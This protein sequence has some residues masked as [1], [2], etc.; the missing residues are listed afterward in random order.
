[1]LF[2]ACVVRAQDVTLPAPDGTTVTIHRDSYGVPHVTGTTEAGVFF[3]QGFACAED[4]LFQMETY[5]RAAEGKLCEWYGS[6]YL[7]LDQEIRR[8]FYTPAERES[9]FTALPAEIQAMF[10]AYA[11]GVNA[12]LDSMAADPA[13]Y[14]PYEFQEYSMETPWTSLKSVAV[15][16][17]IIGAFGQFGGYELTRLREL[18]QNG[19]AWFDQYRPINDPSA[20]V[21]LHDGPPAPAR[22]W[23]YSGM[24]V[25]PEVSRELETRQAEVERL[26][27]EIGIPTSLGSFAT[28]IAE[29]KSAT[30]NVLALGCPQMG[31]PQLGQANTV[32]EVEL[33]CP[34]FHV[35]GMTLAGTPGVIIGRNE[36]LTWTLTSGI[37]DNT[38]LYI[39][40]T[41]SA[42]YSRYWH[43][44]TWHD[45]EVITDTIYVRNSSPNI[46]T[47]YRTIHGPVSGDDLTN[48]QTFSLK[49]TFRGRELDMA[50]AALAMSRAQTLAEFETAIA[51][52]PMSFNVFCATDEGELGFWHIGKYQDRE[53]GVDPR[54]PH[55]GDGSEEWH[56]FIPFENLPHGTH[57]DQDYYVNWNN[58]PVSWWNNGDN[59][60]WVGWNPVMNIDN[61]V[62]PIVSFTY[63]NLKH[64]P[65][66]ISDHGSYQQAMEF[67]LPV[68][69]DENIAPP[70]QSA[71]RD[72][73]GNWSP[74]AADQWPLH[75]AWQFK[76]MEFAAP[77][78]VEPGSDAS[79]LRDVRFDPPYP[80]PFNPC[81]TLSFTL[82]VPARVK[83]TVYDLHGRL[84]RV[85]ADR[86]FSIGEHSIA[87][88][89]GALPSGLYFVRL[90]A[91]GHTAAH[92]LLLL[93]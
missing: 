43:S 26:F 81:T 10:N 82:P 86:E 27:H 41:E 31:A 35:G 72:S 12:Y 32:H 74:H 46:F 63:D 47:H 33:Q 3:G 89:A 53:D 14:R 67:A 36:H 38:D 70:G 77:S 19:Q 25:R 6:A 90:S 20:P 66:Q 58:K 62:A 30:G 78:S 37:S 8:L 83:L 57:L 4:R 21:T 87:L 56:G 51:L 11:A 45:F 9:L 60:P 84:V 85:L 55:R 64:V 17:F 65:E 50:R 88:D 42:A 61:Y 34:M 40:S 49:W 76:D 92:K 39:D 75:Q 24:R 80:N 71:F 48:H 23:R 44:G 93:K 13:R 52:N 5:R 22:E 15:S 59:V 68:W 29:S 7:I 2:F 73:E 79:L 18:Q 69:Q 91:D 1:M 54:L 28:L 16:Q